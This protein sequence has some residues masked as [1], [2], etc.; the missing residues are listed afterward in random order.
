MRQMSVVVHVLQYRLPAVSYLF[1]CSA[2]GAKERV[3]SRAVWLPPL[4]LCTPH[5][6]S[7][8]LQS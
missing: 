8:E 1:D 6:I 5:I 4:Q 7:A 2:S 3:H